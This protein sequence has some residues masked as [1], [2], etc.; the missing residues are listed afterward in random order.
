MFSKFSDL[1]EP[2]QRAIQPQLLAPIQR[3]QRGEKLA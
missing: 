3:V 1:L 2:R